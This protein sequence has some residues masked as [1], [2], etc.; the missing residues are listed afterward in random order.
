MGLKNSINTVM[1]N[2]KEALNWVGDRDETE[3]IA[4]VAADL[5]VCVSIGRDFISMIDHHKFASIRKYLSMGLN[6]EK[7]INELAGYVKKPERAYFVLSYVR[8]VILSDSVLAT[9]MMAFIIF[10]VSSENRDASHE[11]MI[12]LNALCSMTDYDMRNMNYLCKNCVTAE[13]GDLSVEKKFDVDKI[14]GE[15]LNSC[16]ITLNLLASYGI[17]QK[18]PSVIDGGDI[19]KMFDSSN[20]GQS[21]SE[22]AD[23]VLDLD[24]EYTL[25]SVTELFYHYMCSMSQ[26][27]RDELF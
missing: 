10:K 18:S 12:I 5:S 16:N 20:A 4:N 2:A 6:E 8:K 11:E 19:G 23:A 7:S 13:N 26:L 1:T 15:R 9:S 27:Y 14:G 17:V 25:T 24:G 3:D 21:S 22:K